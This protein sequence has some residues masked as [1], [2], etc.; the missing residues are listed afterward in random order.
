M[1]SLINTLNWRYACKKMNGEMIPSEKLDTIL[2]ATNLTATSYGLQ[3]FTI[4][5]VSNN[6]VKQ[7]LQAAAY[8]QV[9]V[10]TASHV[11]VF[12]VPTKLTEADAAT[13][14]ANIA[15]TRSMPVE[16]LAGYQ[17]MIAGTINSLDEAQQQTWAAKQA[18]IALGTALIAAADQEVD[19]CPMEGFNIAQV[20]EVLGLTEKGLTAV[21]LLPLGYRAADDA[22][23]HYKKVR[24]ASADMF[25]RVD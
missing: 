19:A 13:F 22:T 5:V 25:L 14:I 1:M 23:A 11:L 8:G 3:P 20:N 7:K 2:E 10:G 17:A 16:A 4:A 21:V 9:Q 15:A 18:Y 24:K 6:E 12:C